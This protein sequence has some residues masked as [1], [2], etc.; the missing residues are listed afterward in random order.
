[1]TDALLPP[2]ITA[3][4]L[5]A[6]SGVMKLRDPSVAAVALAELGVP[7]AQPLVLSGAAVELVVAALL[8]AWPAAGAPAAATLYVGFAI[9][10]GVQLRRG[11]R[12]SCGCFGSAEAPPSRAH[13]VVDLAFASVCAA[14]V[15]TGPDPL[16]VL[17]EP[18]TG[19]PLYVAAAVTAWLVVTGLELLPGALTAYRKPTG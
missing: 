11:A 14:A 13:V 6:V 10:V 3:A 1:M 15:A 8:L 4:V 19:V 2:L 17:L 12:R 16:K 9:L 7:A 5:L 18:T